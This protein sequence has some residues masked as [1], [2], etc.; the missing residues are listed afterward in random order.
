[1]TRRAQPETQLQRSVIA[2]LQWRARPGVWWTHIPLGGLR[3]KVEAAILRGLG[4]ARGTPDLL[5]VADGKAHFLEL[6]SA[7][8]RATDAQ[9][10]CHEALRALAPWSLWRAESTRHSNSSKFGTYFAACAASHLDRRARG[11][12]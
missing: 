6:K 8:G 10:Q 4:T 7:G 5:I 2:Q 9:R 1:M 12:G 3:S 11:S